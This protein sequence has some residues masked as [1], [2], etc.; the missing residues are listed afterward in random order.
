MLSGLH[1]L[2]QIS[3]RVLAITNDQSSLNKS[4]KN[5]IH[6]MKKMYFKE[7]NFKYSEIN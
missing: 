3:E 1:T 4:L 5:V 6:V 7:N 2:N